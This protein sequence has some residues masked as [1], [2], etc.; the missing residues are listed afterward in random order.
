MRIKHSTPYRIRVLSDNMKLYTL[1]AMLAAMTN[2]Q[3]RN[4]ELTPD[5]KKAIC[6]RFRF[7]AKPRLDCS[8]T[9]CSAPINSTR[10]RYGDCAQFCEVRRTGII[11]EP[12]I[13]KTAW[14]GT[15]PGWEI[16]DLPGGKLIDV[17]L[18]GVKGGLSEKHM[19][20]IRAS[21]NF[22]CTYPSQLKFFSLHRPRGAR[23]DKA[24]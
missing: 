19:E 24:N 7:D 18:N 14:N 21:L 3:Q 22:E 1:L 17:V 8:R 10:S 2:A 6:P 20:A 13:P 16:K 5:P 23:M 12:Q 4:D 15:T 9:T 11:G